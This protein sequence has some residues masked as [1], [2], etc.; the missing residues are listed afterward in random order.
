MDLLKTQFGKQSPLYQLPDPSKA[1]VTNRIGH[2]DDGV[3]FGEK[4]PTVSGEKPPI[5]PENAAQ[6]HCVAAR[7]KEI[8]DHSVERIVLFAMSPF[9]DTAA[10]RNIW[11]RTVLEATE[12]NLQ[13]QASIRGYADQ[14]RQG[15]S[16]G[17][18]R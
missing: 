1:I 6:M 15:R 16:R 7:V 10:C 3:A 9:S 5:V 13:F 18:R 11:L 2:N 8:V 14:C 4:R 12:D 17:L